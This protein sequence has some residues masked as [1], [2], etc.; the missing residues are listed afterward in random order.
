MEQIKI[1][2]VTAIPHARTHTLTRVCIC[3]KNQN[4]T[5]PCG[6]VDAEDNLKYLSYQTNT[7]IFTVSTFNAFAN[8]LLHVSMKLHINRINLKQ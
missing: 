6:Y 7:P 3:Q 8:L 5:N 1:M 4:P 2:E